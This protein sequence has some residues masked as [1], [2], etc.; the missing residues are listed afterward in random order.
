[1]ATLQLECD[2]TQTNSIPPFPTE[3]PY[4]WY[5]ATPQIKKIAR[6]KTSPFPTESP[7]NSAIFPSPSFLGFLLRSIVPY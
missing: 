4:P 5:I 6:L 1:M 7:Y 2:R 3:F